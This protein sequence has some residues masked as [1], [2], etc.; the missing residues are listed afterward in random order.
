MTSNDYSV[1]VTDGRSNYVSDS[2]LS[3][4]ENGIRPKD[5][6]ILDSGCSYHMYPNRDW[7]TTYR[8]I[9]GG[10]VLIGNNVACKT[11][12]IGIVKAKMY[13]GIVRTLAKVRH[14]P[15][16]K[17]NL[18]SLGALDSDGC[19]F[20]AEGRVMKVVKG[21]LVLMRGNK[22]GNLYILSGNTITGGAAVFSL[23]DHEYVSTRLWHL[24]LGHMSKKGLTILSNQNLLCGTKTS[25]LDF[26]ERCIFGK[27]RK[28]SFKTGIHR[29]K[30]ILDYVHS[31]VWGP[32]KVYSKGGSRFMLTFIN[33]YSR[34]VCVYTLKTKDHTFVTFKRWKE[35]VEK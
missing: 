35:M 32:S 16:L 28:V 1:S 17:K 14:V 33:D 6:W 8:E 24:R 9:N 27:H 3:V 22:V 31:D 15:D 13:D 11:V 20:S 4:I 21:A 30:G 23:D 7:F 5:E 25:K 2:A 12:G 18:V 10:S 26:C 34:K 29:T 19:K